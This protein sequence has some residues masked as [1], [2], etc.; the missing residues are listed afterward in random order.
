M[1]SYKD[2]KV[3]VYA[4]AADEPK[5]FIDRWLESMKPADYICVLITKEGNS[6]LYYFNEKKKEYPNLIVRQKTIKPWR[7]D[8]AR[9]T[10]M[11]LIPQDTVVAVSTDIDEVLISDFWDD[12]RKLVFEHSDF[13]K[14]H[15]KFAWSLD[16][17]NN[18]KK[19]FWYDRIIKPGKWHWKYPVHEGLCSDDLETNNHHYWLDENKIYLKHYPDDSKSRSS[20]LPL[21]ELRFQENPT[22]AYSGYYLAREYSFNNIWDK[23]LQT[24]L[25]SYIR[26]SNSRDQQEMLAPLSR[27]IGDAFYKL[28]VRDEAEHWYKKA[29]KIDPKCRDGY[30]KLAQL[31][32]YQ[33]TPDLVFKTLDDM[34][35]NSTILYDWKCQAIYNRE[36]KLNQILADAKCW[37]G[38]YQEAARLMQLALN[39]VKQDDYLDAS[40]EGLFKDAKF[41]ENKINEGAENINILQK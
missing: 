10:S 37:E 16:A 38:N 22:D 30:M 11:K 3:A 26:L 34:D 29:I 7:F 6:N 13:E 35:R 24:A 15:Y 8:V 9:N 2:V 41:I 20:Y 4:I 21:L 36:W 5:E 25:Q 32:A 17:Q 1:G 31:Y 39:D 14:I 28:N 27:F 19:V 33:A 18:P 40:R 23:M 12:L